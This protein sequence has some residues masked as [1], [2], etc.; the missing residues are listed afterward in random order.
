MLVLNSTRA[1]AD[2]AAHVRITHDAI[3]AWAGSLTPTTLVPSGHELIEHIPGTREQIANFT[4]LLDALNFCF[5]SP[6]PIRIQW[7]GRT[8]ERFSAMMVSLILAAKS[9]ARWFDPEFWM[10]VSREEIRQVL[11]GNGEL[12]LMDE[13]ERVMRETGRVLVDR[14]D[15]SFASAVASVGEKAWPLAVL[16]MTN[17]DSF[18]D[19]SNFRGKPVYFMKRAQICALD[20]SAA[21]ESKGHG[22]LEGL[23]ELT[24]FADYRVPQ[25]LRHL[26]ILQYSSELEAA[27]EAERELAADSEAEIEIR[28]ATIQAVDLM[29]RA[30][31]KAGRSATAWEVD[32]YLWGLSHDKSV[33]V[34]HHRTRTVYY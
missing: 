18:R 15:G 24:A 21:W 19:V 22:A 4:L 34:K 11:S 25:G 5:W 14:F 1:V 2:A 6:S 13:R 7:R 16:L 9:D 3:A 27:I 28:A 20:L 32:W 30:A 23:G 29:V 17:F 26:D 31:N 33:R 10:V 8:Y 12:L